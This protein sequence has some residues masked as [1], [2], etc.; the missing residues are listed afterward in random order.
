MTKRTIEPVDFTVD[1]KDAM[2]A[3]LREIADAIESDTD[4]P[5]LVL[6]I[7]DPGEGYLGAI[8]QSLDDLCMVAGAA[9][10]DAYLIYSADE[11]GEDHGPN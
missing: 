10:T 11:E 4:S 5:T 8:H 6:I 9:L 2:V 7:G 3:K 1:G